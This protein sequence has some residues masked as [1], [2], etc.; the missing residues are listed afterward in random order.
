M[1][2][3]R[4]RPT[5]ILI[6]S[7]P[8]HAALTYI[9]AV[10]SYLYSPMPTVDDAKIMQKVGATILCAEFDAATLKLRETGFIKK[11]MPFK[12][13]PE[14]GKK[15]KADKWCAKIKECADSMR[16]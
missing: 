14:L 2:R 9:Q 6:R 16:T 13:G 1:G 3:R 8:L 10:L 15:E 12:C 11:L 7:D 4:L 5:E